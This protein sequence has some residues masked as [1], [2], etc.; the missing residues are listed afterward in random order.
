MDFVF[1]DR[2]PLSITEI[3]RFNI[4]IR[5]CL[6]RGESRRVKVN[7]TEA[8]RSGTLTPISQPGA[9]H[10]HSWFSSVLWETLLSGFHNSPRIAFSKLLPFQFHPGSSHWQIQP[11]PGVKLGWRLCET[12]GYSHDCDQK[13]GWLDR[14]CL[15]LG[16]CRVLGVSQ[17]LSK[18]FLS[19]W[20]TR[21]PE[22]KTVVTL[23]LGTQWHTSHI[24]MGSL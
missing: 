11:A 7:E 16:V 9:K 1:K 8:A 15:S 20:L 22:M 2:A 24:T 21:G 5:A 10:R 14:R 18:C 4:W 12:V 3:K 19:D 23:S 17:M 13:W 6:N